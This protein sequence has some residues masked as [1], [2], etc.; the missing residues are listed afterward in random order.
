MW[1]LEQVLFG[2]LCACILRLG[3]CHGFQCVKDYGTFCAV[4]FKGGDRLVISQITI[5][6]QTPEVGWLIYQVLTA[7]CPLVFD[8]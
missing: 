8:F 5:Q 3:L 2:A 4:L 1:T 6:F 7:K